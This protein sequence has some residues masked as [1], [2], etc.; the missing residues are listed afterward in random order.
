[1][2]NNLP[3]KRF[4][5]ERHLYELAPFQ[6]LVNHVLSRRA[7]IFG[8]VVTHDRHVIASSLTVGSRFIVKTGYLQV[9]EIE[10]VT[11]YRRFSVRH[12]AH[13]CLS[14]QVRLEKCRPSIFH[15]ESWAHVGNGVG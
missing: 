12:E 10:G 6:R 5:R 15:T 1:M 3:K 7:L 4:F 14:L 2:R 13:R 11:R 9:S 8:K